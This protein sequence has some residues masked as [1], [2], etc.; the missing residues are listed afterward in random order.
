MLYYYQYEKEWYHKKEIYN[1]TKG[2]YKA[3]RECKSLSSTDKQHITFCSYCKIMF[4]TFKS[5]RNRKDILCPFGCRYIH[6]KK[7]AEDRCKKYRETIMGKLKKKKL[8]ENRYRKNIKTPIKDYDDD[9]RDDNDTN[10]NM[11]SY[12]WFLFKCMFFDPEN[13]NWMYKLYRFLKKIF[14]NRDSSA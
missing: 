9:F 8:N 4:F 3:L 6:K 7:M 10:L 5:N 11:T 12:C 14:R 1:F 13:P 2:Y